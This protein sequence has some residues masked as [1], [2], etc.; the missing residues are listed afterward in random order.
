MRKSKVNV[1][2][3]SALMA[4]WAQQPLYMYQHKKDSL[5]NLEVCKVGGRERRDEREVVSISV[6][7]LG[8]LLLRHSH[9]VGERAIIEALTWGWGEGYYRGT[10]G[11]QGN[12]WQCKNGGA[13]LD[14]R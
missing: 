7:G 13:T 4:T 6:I 3:I 10:A 1:E 2:S 9:G 14:C 12:L 8:K 11:G 5:L